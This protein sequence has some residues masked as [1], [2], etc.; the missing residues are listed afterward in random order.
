MVLLMI[1]VR[2]YRQWVIRLP[3]YSPIQGQAN[4]EE[5]LTWTFRASQLQCTLCAVG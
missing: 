5:P 4:A 1:F 3:N 2:P